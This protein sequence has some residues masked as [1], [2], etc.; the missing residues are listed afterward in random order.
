MTTQT[1]GTAGAKTTTLHC[2]FRPAVG[3]VVRVCY[4]IEGPGPGPDR[5]HVQPAEQVFVQKERG[6][7]IEEVAQGD[8]GT[9]RTAYSLWVERLLRRGDSLC[10]IFNGGTASYWEL[11]ED[12]SWKYTGS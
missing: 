1:V 10:F 8:V 6:L 3:E 4:G 2:Q 7:E 9:P 5:E 12:L 11:Q